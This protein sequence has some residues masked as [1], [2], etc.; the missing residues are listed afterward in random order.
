VSRLDLDDV[1]RDDTAGARMLPIITVSG[2]LAQMSAAAWASLVDANTPPRYFHYGSTLVRIEPGVRP[3]DAPRLRTLHVDELRHEL[4]RVADWETARTKKTGPKPCHP[5]VAVVRD[6]LAAPSFRVPPLLAVTPVPLVVADGTI[7]NEPGYHPTAHTYYAPAE[8]F[9][10]AP[11]PARP[12]DE[13]V[14]TAVTMITDVF[15][16]FPFLEASDRANAIAAL[17]TIF[18]REMIPDP[19][20]L[21]MLTKPSPGTGATLLVHAISTLALGTE[22]GGQTLSENDDEIRK[23]ITATLRG[24]PR[25]VLLDNLRGFLDSGALSSVLTTHGWQD[26]L[27]GTND[28]LHLP[29]RCV[30]FGTSNNATWTTELGRRITPIRL[31]A[32]VE[33]PWL[34][35]GF[36]H[37]DLLEWITARRAT[38]VHACLTLVTA[39]LAHGRPPGVAR[40]GSY[41]RW[42]MVLGG[43]LKVAGI[44]GFLENLDAVCDDADVESDDLRQF[45]ALWWKRH[46]TAP[47]SPTELLLVATEADVFL[48]G[49]DDAARKKSLGWYLRR[50]KDRVIEVSPDVNVRIR[51][52]KTSANSPLWQVQR[53][54]SSGGSCGF[55]GFSPR[56]THENDGGQLDISIK[57]HEGKTTRTPG[58]PRCSRCGAHPTRPGF[59]WCAACYDEIGH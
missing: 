39:W 54:G 15:A 2:D 37:P 16:D 30:W 38:L 36:A 17:L 31:D 26:R 53:P 25:L 11:I 13:D 45:L 29:V 12:T 35:H 19:T 44:E 20:P 50:H 33:R 59:Q 47:V 56:A 58:T 46:E 8:G 6:L 23:V 18:V 14:T 42:S 1:A 5:P 34:R 43:I 4:A 21:F 48:K 51:R 10:V 40:H 49:K 3:G 28:D 7:Q 24:A 55:G 32:G 22:P 57:E 9:T 27:L 52:V 41:A